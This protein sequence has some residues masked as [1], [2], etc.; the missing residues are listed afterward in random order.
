MKIL[1]LFCLATFTFLPIAGADLTVV[2]SIE[3]KNNEKAVTNKVTIKIKGDR[4]RI[5]ANPKYAMIVDSKTGEVFALVPENK[6]FQRFT[7]EQAA[8][9]GDKFRVLAK[10]T[11]TS[12]E[13]ATP[14]PTGKKE[15]INGYEAD[16]YVAETPKYKA[17]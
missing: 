12:L 15:K 13:I 8:A 5:Q 6:A 1:P 2:Q 14:K 10:D 3:S 16:E 17:S 9:Q 11:D 4:A 7:A